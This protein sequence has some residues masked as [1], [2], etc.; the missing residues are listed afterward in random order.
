MK[1]HTHIQLGVDL[2]GSKIELVAM[3]AD[4]S[5]ILFKE[6]IPTPAANCDEDLRYLRILNA[7]KNLVVAAE[8]HLQKTLPAEFRTT[9]GIGIPGAISPQ[10]GLVKNANTTCLIGRPF[11]S[12]LKTHL[13]R[14]LLIANDA[15]C[16]AL[17]EACDGAG[18]KARSVFGVIIGT[19]CGGGIVVNQQLLSGPN[20]IAGEWGHN[21]LPWQTASDQANPCYCG[22]SGCIETFLSGPGFCNHANRLWPHA[23]PWNAEQWHAAL[24][25]GQ[26]AAIQA[27]DRYTDWLARGL[28]SVINVLDPEVI[29]LGGGM[30]NV[31]YLYLNLPDKLKA[32]VFSDVIETQLAKAQHGDSSGVRGAA[33]LGAE[34]GE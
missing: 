1:A 16:F 4:S 27:F 32:Y 17:S 14:D 15:D 13:A 3:A 18:K 20:A 22:K 9:L 10:T 12:D 30:S 6:R 24:L 23:T 28:A 31:D 5:D 11:Q 7:I 8:Q 34:A 21:P 29:V 33:W 26:Q 19:G 25:D 2:G